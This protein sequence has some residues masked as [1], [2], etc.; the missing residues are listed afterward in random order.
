MTSHRKNGIIGHMKLYIEIGKAALSVFALLC[1]QSVNL[2]AGTLSASA[3]FTDSQVSPGVYQYDLTLDNT[4]TTS[5]GTFW[6]SWI[7]G[8]GFMTATPTNIVNP[9]GWTD[10]VTNSGESIQ[11][12][13][14]GVLSAG[15][16]Q[17]GFEFD[18]T[19]TPT[20]LAGDATSTVYTGEPFSSS[21]FEFVA[22][23]AAGS[24][25]EPGTMLLTALG[26]CGAAFGSKW[27][28]KPAS[29]GRR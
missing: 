18:S 6:F 23:P 17:S 10:S 22:T 26:I 20:E 3:T 25:P 12:V 29:S 7:P 24:V 13:D 8:E 16:S 9:S 21:P 11:W 2:C 19:L 14:S 15:L 28:G 4:G 5:I 27:L 1:V